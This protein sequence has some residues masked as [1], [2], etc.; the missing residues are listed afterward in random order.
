MGKKVDSSASPSFSWDAGS[1]AE[2]QI[3]HMAPIQSKPHGKYF[4]YFTF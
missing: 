4:Y 2:P 3:S 1:V